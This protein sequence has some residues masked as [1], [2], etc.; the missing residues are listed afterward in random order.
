[1]LMKNHNDPIG[2]R[3]R[4]LPAC[5]EVCQPSAAPVGTETERISVFFFLLVRIQRFQLKGNEH[6]PASHFEV[7]QS[8][9]CV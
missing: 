1:M 2:N 8:V 9:H 7:F 6:I 5:S 3:T 4:E